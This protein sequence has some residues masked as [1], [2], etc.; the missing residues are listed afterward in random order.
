MNRMK[1]KTLGAVIAVTPLVVLTACAG[2]NAPSSEDDRTIVIADGGGSYHDGMKEAIYDPCAAETGLT[3]E[4]Q[5][6]DYSVGQIKTQVEGAKEWDLV[7]YP[8]YVTEEE[9]ADYFLPVDY[10]VVVADG[11]PESAKHKYWVDYD[12]TGIALG[13]RTDKYPTPPE[14]WAALWDV[15]N[16]P[17]PAT[18]EATTVNQ[19]LQLALLADG[20]APA[21]MYPLDLDRAFAKMDELMEMREVSY[22]ASGADMIQKYTSG[23]A[24]IGLSM[25]G[26]FLNAAAEGAPL[27]FAQEGTILASTSWAP[28]KTAPNPEGAMEFINCAM[29]A[30]NQAAAANIIRGQYPVNTLAFALLDPELQA[31]MPDLESENVLL[32][33]QEYWAENFT[34]VH[35]R[36]QDWIASK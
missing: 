31:V 22:F 7:T 9:A 26:R 34:A 5:T 25:S 35:E 3:I 13:Y 29:Q 12:L 1:S 36:W 15:E 6:F 21:D 4:T 14:N 33:N 23:A 17:G 19:N 2:G 16:Y 24:T 8:T 28:L 20:V 10:S 32:E 30:K 18:L 27:S 11:I